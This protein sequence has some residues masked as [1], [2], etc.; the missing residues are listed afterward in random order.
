MFSAD[1]LRLAETVL[2]KARGE[3]LRLSTAESCTGGLIAGCLTE[4]PGASDVVDR[5][6]VVYS[7]QAKTDLLGVPAETIAHYG[8]VSE[9][10]A[11]AMAK[12]ALER[13]AVHLAVS[14]TGIAGPSGGTML[15]PV[16]LVH[17]AALRKD[18]PMLH[19]EWRFGDIGRTEVRLR[20]VDAALRLLVRL[21]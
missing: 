11:H 5:G 4:I 13:A 12:G 3:G 9:E 20:T 8:A 14:C 1:L 21:L 10:V 15:K 17:I 6:F 2:I 18:R 19:E 16:G 7:D